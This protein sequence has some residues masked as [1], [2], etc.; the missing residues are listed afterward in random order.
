MRKLMILGFALIWVAQMMW[1]GS[2]TPAAQI[3]A[4]YA[5]ADGLAGKPLWTAISSITNRGFSSLGYNGL[6]TAYKKT[7]VYPADSV[8]KAGKI[9]DMYGECPFTFS[10]DQCGSYNGVCDCYNREHSIPKSWFGGSTNGI[11]CR[12]EE[13]LRKRNRNGRYLVNRSSYDRFCGW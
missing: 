13:L 7:D 6:W 12:S 3:P 1:A 4:Y 8:G 5:D 10:S 11:G 2:V 9:W